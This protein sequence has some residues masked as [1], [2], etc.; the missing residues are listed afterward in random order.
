[1][2]ID[3]EDDTLYVNQGFW[4]VLYP[5]S[6]VLTKLNSFNVTQRQHNS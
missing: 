5:C 6:C 1:M 3:Q 4:D 2:Q